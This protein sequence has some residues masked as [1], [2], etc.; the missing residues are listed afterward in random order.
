VRQYLE[1]RQLHPYGDRDGPQGV[2]QVP[3]AGV[4]CLFISLPVVCSGYLIQYIF[5]GIAYAN[6]SRGHHFP[7]RDAYDSFYGILLRVVDI[8]FEDLA[9]Y[10]QQLLVNHLRDTMSARNP[11]SGTRRTGLVHVAGTAFVNNM[12]VEVDWRDFKKNVP[13]HQLWRH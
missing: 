2:L 12:G 9:A 8:A 3:S 4:R 6:Y 7:S 1:S 5:T 13:P 10:I 11:P